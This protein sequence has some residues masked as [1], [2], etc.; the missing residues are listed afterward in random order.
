LLSVE[1]EEALFIDAFPGNVEAARAFGL[2][3]IHSA[4]AEALA[5]DL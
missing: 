5:S 2:H 4:T 1:P 3:G